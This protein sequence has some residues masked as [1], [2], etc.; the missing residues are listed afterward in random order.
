M[1]S[2]G[3]R[4]IDALK[5]IRGLPLQSGD[6]NENPPGIG[7]LALV[8][9]DFNTY[10]RDLRSPGFWAIAVHRFGNVRMEVRSRWRRAPLTIIYR[11][12]YRVV[13]GAFGIELPYNARIGR[14]FHIGH[15]GGV[16]MGA[17]SVGDDVS[18]HHTATIGLARRSERGTAP[19]IGSRVE[20]GPGA[21]IIGDIEIGDDCYIGANSL[22][23]FSILAGTSVLGVPARVADLQEYESPGPRDR[24]LLRP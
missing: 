13:L 5:Y 21:C 12:A 8:K 6:T 2:L 14:R 9:E 22:L 24:G 3:T 17:R 7:F 1:N 4:K 23:G 11:I 15:H 18:I 16:H 10:N 19:T 20:I